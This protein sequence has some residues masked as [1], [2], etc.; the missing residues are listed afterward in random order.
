MTNNKK[1]ELDEIGEEALEIMINTSISMFLTG[2]GGTGKTF[3]INHFLNENNKLSE[4]KQKKVQMLATTGA[5]AQLYE[6]GETYHSFFRIFGEKLG[7]VNKEQKDVMKYFDT[8]I[9]D[10]ASMISASQFDLINRRLQQVTGVHNKLFGGKQIIF[11]GHLFQA[12]PVVTQQTK[13]EYEEH[14]HKKYDDVY[15]SIFFF[16][17]ISFDTNYFKI[18]ELKK[19]H[20]TTDIK[21]QTYLKNLMLGENLNAVC[22][23]FNKNFKEQKDIN[24]DKAIYIA[25]TNSKV[26]KYNTLKLAQLKADG[27]QIYTSTATYFNWDK[28]NYGNITKEPSPLEIKYAVGSRIIFNKNTDMF[29][30][31]TMGTII[32]ISTIHD[33][34]NNKELDCVEVL[35]D[36][37]TIPLKIIKETWNKY[38]TLI[39]GQDEDGEDILEHQ[40]IGNYIQFPFQLGWALTGHKSQ[41]K[42]FDNIIVDIGLVSYKEGNEWKKKPQNHI[43]YVALSR[44]TSY[45]GIQIVQKLKPEFIAVDKDVKNICKKLI[46]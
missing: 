17:A 43:V 20:R 22:S 7:S 12:S 42:T 6:F 27:Q 26:D 2:N 3:L 40:I 19:T 34:L 33:Y 23:Y 9:I 37:K 4:K 38:E 46:K 41:G 44:A 8:Y 13:D 36:G 45:E 21:L 11:V 28:D 10:E 31:G 1:I 39:V 30:N 25:N 14:Y 35:L 24:Y 29:K 18:I 5:A 32:N 15:K 16:D